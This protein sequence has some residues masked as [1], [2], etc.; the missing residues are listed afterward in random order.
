MIRKISLL[1][2]AAMLLAVLA[3]CGATKIVHCDRCGDEIEL[4][5]GDKIEEDWI[6]FCKTCEEELF[7]DNP[8]VD[9]G[10]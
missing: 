10:N 4:P 1:L 3:G 9:P 7:G 8:V 5:A 2:A 6:V